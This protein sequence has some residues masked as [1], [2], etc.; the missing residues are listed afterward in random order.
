MEDWLLI[1]WNANFVLLKMKEIVHIAFCVD[2]KNVSCLSVAL[3]SIATFSS[4]NFAYVVHIVHDGLTYVEQGLLRSVCLDRKNFSFDFIDVGV[5]GD[6][7]SK[8]F[9][10]S[11]L[12]NATYW[13]FALPDYLKNLEKVIYLDADLVV[14]ED[15]A[16]LFFQDVEDLALGACLDWG[17]VYPSAFSHS[18][19]ERAKLEK[20]GYTDFSRY[21]NA[22]VL[23]LNLK[24]FRKEQLSLKLL[25]LAQE[26]SFHMHDQDALNVLLNGKFKVLDHR[27]N[28]AVH[29]NITKY[30]CQV[31]KEI[32]DSISKMDM[33]I[34]HYVGAKKPWASENGPLRKVWVMFAVQT[35]F[36]VGKVLC[37]RSEDERK[38]LASRP[39]KWRKYRRR[40]E[41]IFIPK[42][43]HDL[44]KRIIKK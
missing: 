16:N 44:K 11:Y 41:E 34:I 39:K 23:L 27:W 10:S 28:F 24:F 2:S 43:L 26:N 38:I 9:I 19:D 33:A 40:L 37:S 8:L 6:V 31:Q 13:R 17:V 29:P 15:V 18:T 14:L 4:T 12:S 30:D 36:Y 22:G 25:K 20:L 32:D 42:F 7:F 5:L 35:P 21:F 1:S 3:K